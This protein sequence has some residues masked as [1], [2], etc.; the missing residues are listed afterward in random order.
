M[1]TN[2]N[3]QQ[4]NNLS[5]IVELQQRKIKSLQEEVNGLSAA[6]SK[7]VREISLIRLALNRLGQNYCFDQGAEL[8]LISTILERY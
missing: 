5:T 8:A 2:N 6:H 3:N 4:T 7:A 1:A